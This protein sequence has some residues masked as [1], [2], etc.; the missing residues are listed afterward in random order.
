MYFA[1]RLDAGLK[2]RFIYKRVIKMSIN[3]NMV[4][5]LEAEGCKIFGFADLR[6]LPEEARK[7]SD[8]GIIMGEPYGGE[9]MRENLTGRPERFYEN[10]E[11]TLE[12]LER[13][14]QTV[15]RCLK[16]NGYKANTKYLSTVIT[17]KMVG[18][19]SGLGWIGRCARGKRNPHY[20]VAMPAGL[21]RLRRHL[22]H[23]CH[24]RRLVGTGH[25][26]RYLL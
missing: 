3:Q 21:Q 25:P 23:P 1:K 19:L 10:S 15:I 24:Q 20:P 22:S 5:L 9:G 18:T 14:K 7:G 12:P 26:P 13:Y 6:I 8:F 17:H 4:R 11:A 16:E 2:F